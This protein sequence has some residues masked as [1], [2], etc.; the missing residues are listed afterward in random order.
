[1]IFKKI[2]AKKFNEN[3]DIFLLKLLLVFEKK[4]IIT[5]FFLRKT[6]IFRRK[7]AKI[8]ENND[9]NIDPRLQGGCFLERKKK[10]TSL[11]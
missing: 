6:P 11:F 8:A 10:R 4:L 3:V 2:F 5:L 7:L 1:M 9:H